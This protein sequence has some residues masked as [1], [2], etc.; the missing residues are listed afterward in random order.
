MKFQIEVS[1]TRWRVLEV[2]AGTA[3]EAREQTEKKYRDGKIVLTPE[4]TDET[5]EVKTV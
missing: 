5:F 1:E 4:N 3:D 2:E